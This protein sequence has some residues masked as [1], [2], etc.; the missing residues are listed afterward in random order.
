MD[1]QLLV[2]HFFPVKVDKARQGLFFLW[3]MCGTPLGTCA[4]VIWV[5]CP[6]LEAAN[7][8][9][10]RSGDKQWKAAEITNVS[11]KQELWRCSPS[12]HSVFTQKRID[13][14]D[15][16]GSIETW[17]RR[18]MWIRALMHRYIQIC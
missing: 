13:W 10:V 17:L 8:D 3:N 4:R 2:F 1:I 11:N 15:L 7:P 6:R 14:P 18:H 16:N 12:Y 9:D 5:G